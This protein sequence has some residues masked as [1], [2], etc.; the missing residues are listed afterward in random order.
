D[1]TRR[2]ARATAARPRGRPRAARL[3][4]LVG[5][6][7]AAR[8]VRVPA[9]ELAPRGGLRSTRTLRRGLLRDERRAPAVRAARDGAVRLRA[10]AR[11]RPRAPLRGLVHGRRP[12]L[13]GRAHRRVGR[14]WARRVRLLQ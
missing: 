4:P 1:E 8:R 9:R 5:A 3:L 12:A 13:V 14:R 6:A 2:A 10:T 7:R 11:P